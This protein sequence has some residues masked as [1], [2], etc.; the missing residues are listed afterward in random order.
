MRS[1]IFCPDFGANW[2]DARV[3]STRTPASCASWSETWRFR[4]Q[5]TASSHR[6]FRVNTIKAKISRVA[7]KRDSDEQKPSFEP[8]TLRQR[9][10]LLPATAR[11]EIVHGFVSRINVGSDELEF[12]YR[13][14][15]ISERTAKARH[16]HGPTV[17]PSPNARESDEPLYIR[18]PKPGQLC[19]LT[20]MTRSAL[21]ELI[22]GSE[23][24][25]YQPPVESKSLRKREGGKGTRLIVWQSLKAYLALR[26]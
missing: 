10:P 24:N 20:G 14:R 2:S 6:H 11:R 26:E 9:W 25:N 1:S 4:P 5:A 7:G 19:P 13:F 3:I 8:R 16:F 23:R 18:L 15:E 21:N 17:S 22:L 12:T